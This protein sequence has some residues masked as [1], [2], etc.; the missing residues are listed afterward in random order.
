M[1]DLIVRGGPVMYPLIFCSVVALA[2]G[3]ERLWY[4][5]KARVD[6]EDLIDEIRLALGQGKVLEAVQLAKKTRGPVAATLASGIAHYDRDKE[7]IKAKMEEIGRE[8]IFKMERRLSILEAISVIAPLLGILGTVTGIIK[9]FDVLAGMHGL[10]TA[11]ELSAG[12][13]EALIT[14]ATGL[15]IAIPTMVIYTYLT[16]LIDRFTADMTKRSNELLEVL[17]SRGDY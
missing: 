6:T 2:V 8:E 7:E 9:S 1:L 17:D 14:T 13:A 4:L 11:V 15:I 10:G 3:L 12:I 5:L 16:S